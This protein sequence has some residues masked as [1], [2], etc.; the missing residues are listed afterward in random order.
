MKYIFLL[1]LL[2]TGS[3]A[4][5]AQREPDRAPYLSSAD[6]RFGNPDP[7]MD[8]F[9]FFIGSGNTVHLYLSD[10]RQLN[11]INID[12]IIS[13]VS[14]ALQAFSD[15]LSKPLVSRRIDIVSGVNG[16]RELRFRE[17]PQQG[18]IFRIKGRDTTQIKVEQ[19]TLQIRFFI[20]DSFYEYKGRLNEVKPPVYRSAYLRLLLNNISDLSRI[21]A[22]DLQWAL[23][24]LKTDLGG[25]LH[26]KRK[27]WEQSRY[28]GAY[29]SPEHKALSA[30]RPYNTYS[31]YPYKRF[32][33]KTS[34][35]SSIQYVRGSLAP[36]IGLGQE[37]VERRKQNDLRYYRLF[38]EPFFFFGRNEAGSITMDRN[39]FIT[40][41]WTSEQSDD[42][43]GMN[44]SAS[45]GY[46]IGRRGPWFEPHTI[47]IALPGWQRGNIQ[48]EPEFLFN[49]LFRHF[50]PSLKLTLVFE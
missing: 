42:K 26:T 5:F 30:G 25:A 4:A 11:S 31:E 29:S 24:Q 2:V 18:Q 15:T 10:I 3:W 44:Q 20:L 9:Q 48:L 13:E 47:K 38:W 50:S 1:A 16:T 41:K 12:S 35:Q 33:L 46:L 37:L 21:S 27:A 17:F 22:A 36:S 39:D 32:T 8:H 23:R 7:G 40:F 49:D 19:D 14:M 43:N 45:I 6:L 28:T 34:F